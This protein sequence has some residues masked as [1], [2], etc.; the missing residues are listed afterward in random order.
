MD[1]GIGKQVIPVNR[2]VEFKLNK[3]MLKL[4]FVWLDD[5]AGVNFKGKWHK[6]GEQI[7]QLQALIFYTNIKRWWKLWM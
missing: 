1:D 6:D 4:G 5:E 2:E 3:W 7:T